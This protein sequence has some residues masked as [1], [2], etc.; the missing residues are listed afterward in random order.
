MYNVLLTMKD[1]YAKERE[2]D[3]DDNVCLRVCVCVCSHAQCVCEHTFL[4]ECVCVCMSVCSQWTL[5]VPAGQSLVPVETRWRSL[6]VTLNLMTGS[7]VCL[8][9]F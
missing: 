2:L 4:H 5:T 9:A 6:I 8:S 1:V 7:S 3:R